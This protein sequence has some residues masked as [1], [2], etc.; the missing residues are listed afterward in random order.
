[1]RFA[2]SLRKRLRE[3][4]LYPHGLLTR[5]YLLAK[6]TVPLRHEF[7]VPINVEELLDSILAAEGFVLTALEE[8]AKKTTDIIIELSASAILST[9]GVEKNFQHCQ[10][11]FEQSTALETTLYDML[12]TSNRDI[13]FGENLIETFKSIRSLIPILK[14][15]LQ[16][17][18][19]ERIVGYVLPIEVRFYSGSKTGKVNGPKSKASLLVTEK[20]V[21]LL[22]V[23]S[24]RSLRRFW[25]KSSTQVIKIQT[26]F[27]EDVVGFEIQENSSGEK[28]LVFQAIPNDIMINS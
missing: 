21:S 2:L 18:R 17:E 7:Y 20:R 12:S 11:L 8:L 23:K 16:L 24:K 28:E 15:D 1:M 10:Y 25:R 19:R 6:V 13:T 27:P 9:K 14:R 3:I 5:L 4:A 26:M 22:Q